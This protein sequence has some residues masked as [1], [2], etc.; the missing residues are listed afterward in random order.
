MDRADTRRWSRARVGHD[1]QRNAVCYVDFVKHHKDRDIAGSFETTDMLSSQ[2]WRRLYAEALMEAEPA[3]R[4]P[5]IA[6]AE[7][8]I[9]S[10]YLELCVTPE[11][12]E[13]NIDLQ[14][15]IY[16]LVQLKEAYSR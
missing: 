2:T 15:A 9:F 6:N 4:A 13:H 16:Y 5:L 10:C 3:K 1:R 11:A 8:A 7:R 12:I 14:N